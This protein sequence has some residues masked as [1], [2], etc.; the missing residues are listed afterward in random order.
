M[1]LR[2]LG[3]I[4][5]FPGDKIRLQELFYPLIIRRGLL[6][7]DPGHFKASLRFGIF[8]RGRVGQDLDEGLIDPDLI[9]DIDIDGFDDARDFGFY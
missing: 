5:F 4:E 7:I 3:I 6:Q 1:F 8:E 9:S 2:I